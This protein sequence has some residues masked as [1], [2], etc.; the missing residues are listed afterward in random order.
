MLS[1]QDVIPF[2][3]S[4][5][6]IVREHAVDYFEAAD[7]AGG[8]TADDVWAAID[9]VGLADWRGESGLVSLLRHV[10]QG[11]GSTAKLLAAIAST[12]AEDRGRRNLFGALERLSLELL[13]GHADRVLGVADLPEKTRL[14]LE[15]RLRLADVPVDT[16]WEALFGK[17][18]VVEADGE[19]DYAERYRLVDAL[20]EHGPGL[21]GERALAAFLDAANRDTDAEVYAVELLGRVRHRPA[22]EALAARFAAVNEETGDY[23]LEAMQDAIPWVGG[24]DAVPLIEGPFARADYSFRIYGSEVLGRI[25]HPASEAA[26]VRLLDLPEAQQ[27][28]DNVAHALMMLCTTE[29]MAKLHEEIVVND[30][31]DGRIHD[32][33]RELVA[34]A[35]MT[36]FSFP[37]MGSIRAEVVARDLELQRKIDSGEFDLDFGLNA[38]ADLDDDFEDWEDDEPGYAALPENLDDRQPLPTLP[39]VNEQ[40]KVGRNDPC[41]CGSGKKYKKCCLK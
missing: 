12:P 22:L 35:M 29:A 13:Q 33:E 9:K 23:L 10:P 38:D 15:E 37:E 31:Y 21:I 17:V 7:D 8:L 6:A 30:D 18:V 40:P 24:A 25:K 20:A 14:H 1:P 34:C 19:V 28:W 36:G 41:P 32:L 2:L 27:E 11:D 26:L 16:L 4:D 5:D 39:I 3:S